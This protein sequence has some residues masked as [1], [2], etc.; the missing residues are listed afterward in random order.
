MAL[1]C[2]RCGR[3]YPKARPR[4]V[5]ITVE[6]QQAICTYVFGDICYVCSFE[7]GRLISGEC[8]RLGWFERSQEF[9]EEAVCDG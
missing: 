3:Q 1:V 6:R 8:N 9:P 2:R 7:L 5:S 4:K